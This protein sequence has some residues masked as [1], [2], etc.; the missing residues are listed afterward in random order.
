MRSL[1]IDLEDQL[2]HILHDEYCSSTDTKYQRL[3]SSSSDIQNGIK[4]AHC[5]AY[6]PKTSYG[7]HSLFYYN[8]D[9]YFVT[10]SS[11]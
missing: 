1:S 7:V 6:T 5:W 8:Q 4:L 10:I 3:N 9:S 11:S 2:S